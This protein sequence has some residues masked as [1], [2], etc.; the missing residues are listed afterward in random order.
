[1][2]AFV[3]KN[4][5]LTRGSFLDFGWGNGYVAIPEG[6]PMHGK[7]Y[8]TIHDE[9][10]IDINGGLT[11]S[12][13]AKELR[14]RWEKEGNVELNDTDWVIGFDTAHSWDSL[15]KWPDAESVMIEANRLKEQCE[16]YS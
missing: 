8:D 11:F 13:F 7:D 5:H 1:M 14:P 9:F 15:D 6:H 2:K 10:S 16:S 3:I 4:T 12:C